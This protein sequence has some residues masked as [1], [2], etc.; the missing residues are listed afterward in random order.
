MKKINISFE[1]SVKELKLM[2]RE[3][4]KRWIKT[5]TLADE[6]TVKAGKS[7]YKGPI[8]LISDRGINVGTGFG[9]YF[10]KWENVVAIHKK[11]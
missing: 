8:Y 4:V 2:D 3:T 1:Q 6:A 9:V 11:E 7:V 5:T 10:Y